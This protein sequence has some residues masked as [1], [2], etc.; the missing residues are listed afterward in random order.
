M[1]K[2]TSNSRY[3]IYGLKNYVID[4]KTNSQSLL[5]DVHMGSTAFYIGNGPGYIINNCKLAYQL[6]I[7]N[8]E[9]S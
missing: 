6:A 2:I 4:K 8:G 1:I 3:T 7:D 5:V 9:V